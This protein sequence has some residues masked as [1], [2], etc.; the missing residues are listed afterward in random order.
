MSQYSEVIGNKKKR[1]QSYEDGVI[2]RAFVRLVDNNRFKSDSDYAK[3]VCDAVHPSMLDVDQSRLTLAF[4][5][6]LEKTW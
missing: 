1:D 4:K 2:D 3:G 6:S 5:R